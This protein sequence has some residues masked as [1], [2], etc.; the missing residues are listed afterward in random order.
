M[1]LFCKLAAIRLTVAQALAEARNRQAL[2]AKA[3]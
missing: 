2:N 1:K 3:E